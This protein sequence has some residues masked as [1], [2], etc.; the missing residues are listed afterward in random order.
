MPRGLLRDVLHDHVTAFVPQ[1]DPIT[2]PEAQSS[3]PPPTGPMT[4]GD[5]QSLD[6]Q[7]PAGDQP[8]LEP[9]DPTNGDAQKDPPPKTSIESKEYPHI[10]IINDINS[11]TY[12]MD[13]SYWVSWERLRPTMILPF[14]NAQVPPAAWWQQR[15]D[16]QDTWSRLNGGSVKGYPWMGPRWYPK[17]KWADGWMVD[18]MA[19]KLFNYKLPKW[20]RW[21]DH[22]QPPITR[23]FPSGDPGLPQDPVQTQPPM[24]RDKPGAMIKFFNTGVVGDKCDPNPMSHKHYS[25]NKPTP[26]QLRSLGLEPGVG[27]IKNEAY[28]MM[29]KHKPWGQAGEVNVAELNWPEWFAAHLREDKPGCHCPG[30]YCNFDTQQG[31]FGWASK[32]QLAWENT[33]LLRRQTLPGLSDALDMHLASLRHASVRLSRLQQIK[34]KEAATLDPRPPQPVDNPRIPGMTPPKLKPYDPAGLLANLAYIAGNAAAAALLGMDMLSMQAFMRL[35]HVTHGKWLSDLLKEK[36]AQDLFN[37]GK[38]DEANKLMQEGP[39]AQAAAK[40]KKRKKDLVGQV[41]D[42]PDPPWM[43]PKHTP[44]K[45]EYEAKYREFWPSMEILARRTG[46]GPARLIESLGHE[47]RSHRPHP[48]PKPNYLNYIS[49]S[50]GG[51]I[52]AARRALGGP[53]GR[54]EEAIDAVDLQLP[55]PQPEMHQAKPRDL[56]RIPEVNPLYRGSKVDNSRLAFNGHF[57]HARRRGQPYMAKEALPDVSEGLSNIDAAEARLGDLRKKVAQQE[58]VRNKLSGVAKESAEAAEAEKESMRQMIGRSKKAEA[59]MKAKADKQHLTNARSELTKLEKQKEEATSAFNT[60]SKTAAN[61]FQATHEYP[62]RSIHEEPTGILANVPNEISNAWW[63]GSP[64][65][66][67]PTT[68]A[69]MGPWGAPA[70]VLLSTSWQDTQ[71]LARDAHLA[72]WRAARSRG[73]RR[74]GSCGS[75]KHTVSLCG[76]KASQVGSAFL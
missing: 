16:W 71:H 17:P 63:D 18:K 25:G 30:P 12:V 53:S 36:A 58:V 60:A 33:H 14:V 24:G 55:V 20:W 5:P 52:R 67:G 62:G 72:R 76:F 34:G 32:E 43:P 27:Y 48:N 57:S 19:G 68:Y 42:K 40:K 75:G 54:E 47:W 23:G 37:Q 51:D 73:R 22:R 6:A 35:H 1:P 59:E 29:G 38:Q 44:F 4:G 41:T 7:S 66:P 8:P 15:Y 13:P 11:K 64:Q 69:G 10:G 26:Y 9:E 2:G 74:P 21:L 3:G 50:A 65:P 39:A 49:E 45:D 56:G 61:T 28:S 31:Y 70:A 46:S